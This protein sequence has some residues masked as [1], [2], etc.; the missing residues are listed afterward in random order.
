MKIIVARCGFNRNTKKEVLYGPQELGG[1]SFRHLAVQQGV[2]QASLFLRH[3]RRPQSTTGKLLRVTLSWFQQ[4]AGVLFPILEDVH[5]RLPQLESKWVASLREFLA[6][7]DSS[8]HV[9]NP[10]IKPLQRAHDFM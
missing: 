1:A 10:T 5:T 4:Q 6:S 8:V 2:G 9:D 7:I 3:W